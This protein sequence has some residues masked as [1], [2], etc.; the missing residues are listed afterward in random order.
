MPCKCLE[1]K[2]FSK[3]CPPF[4]KKS[5]SCKRHK[6]NIHWYFNNDEKYMIMQDHEQV[7]MMIK[8]WGL[9]RALYYYRHILKHTE[10]LYLITAKRVYETDALTDCEINFCQKS[11]IEMVEFLK[12]EINDFKNTETR[13]KLTSSLEKLYHTDERQ[14]LLDFYRNL[15]KLLLEEANERLKN[16]KE[17]KQMKELEKDIQ[18]NQAYE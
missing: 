11:I 9:Q 13:Q 3:C 5:V 16:R 15:N 7:D 14:K 8:L 6:F 12:K 17:K 1:T 18:F 2:D 4:D 10:H